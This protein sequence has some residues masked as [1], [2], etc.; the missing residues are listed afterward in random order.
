MRSR[1]MMAA[2]MLSADGATAEPPSSAPSNLAGAEAPVSKTLPTI[3]RIVHVH[4]K[5]GWRSRNGEGSLKQAQPGVVVNAWPGS[6]NANVRVLLDRSCFADDQD[7]VSGDHCISIPV[8]D[9]LSE[10]Q[11]AALTLT[12][13]AEW[14]PRL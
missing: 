8:Y 7:G 5:N 4:L 2:L 3:G 11:R 6:S 9:R 10:E 1:L 14:P 12:V 13:W